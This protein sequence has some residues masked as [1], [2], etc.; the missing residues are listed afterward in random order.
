MNKNI[1][2]KNEKNNFKDNLNIIKVGGS[3][4]IPPQIQTSKVIQLQFKNK[5][6]IQKKII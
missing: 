6:I 1:P 4:K 2:L 5:D 3:L